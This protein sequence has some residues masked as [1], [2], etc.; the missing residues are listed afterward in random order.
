MS[1]SGLC[2]L[3]KV[4]ESL[5]IIPSSERKAEIIHLPKVGNNLYIHVF[6]LT[7]CSLEHLRH[8]SS[9]AT[10][11]K[12]RIG[13]YNATYRKEFWISEAFNIL[14]KLFSNTTAT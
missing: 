5:S 1:I 14:L 3:K 6:L 13:Y 2:S 11:D 12:K 8:K 10:W 7:V 4:R 9:Q